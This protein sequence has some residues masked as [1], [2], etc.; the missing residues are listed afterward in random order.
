MTSARR[1]RRERDDAGSVI[2]LVLGFL[3]FLALLVAVVVDASA[4][5]LQRSGLD[6]LADGAA[7][8]GADL[9]AAGQVFYEQGLDGARLDLTPESARAAVAEY[10]RE[11]GAFE[12]YPGLTVQVRVD[13]ARDRVEVSLSAPADLPL[14]VPG[15]PQHPR[16]GAIGDAVATLD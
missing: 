4:A 9:G 15:S 8:R 10:L 2:P 6:T 7:L 12:R 3:G 1:T 14:T 16:I 11:V 13:T 5:Y